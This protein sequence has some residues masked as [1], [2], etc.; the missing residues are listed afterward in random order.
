MIWLL[1]IIAAYFC[2][3]LASLGDKIVLDGKAQPKSYTFFV[4]FFSILVIFIIP[5]VGLSVP[6]G[7]IWIW[8]ILSALFYILAMYAMFYA[9]E[10]FDVSKIVPTV[11]A[12]QPLFIVA[13]SAIFLGGQSLSQNEIIAFAILLL[14][15]VLISVEKNYKVTKKSLELSLLTAIFFSLQMVFSK[16]VYLDLTFWD[17]FIWMKIFSFAFCLFFF[18]DKGFRTEIFKTDTRMDRKTAT[19]F[20]ITQILGGLANIFEAIAVFAVPLVYLGIMNA[21]KGVQYVFIFIFAILISIFL[22]KLLKEDMSKNIIIRRIIAIVLIGI[23]FAMTI[24]I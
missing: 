16:I 23:G 6:Q 1:A 14:G 5:F 10:R 15:S 18:F 8:I 19:I 22:P 9:L 12:I 4:G 20:F 21:M 7:T 24:I 11:G 13:L 3:A 2:Y 17:A